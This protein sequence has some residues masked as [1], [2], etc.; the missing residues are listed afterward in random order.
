[1]KHEWTSGMI[2]PLYLFVQ[3]SEKIIYGT[4]VWN[5]HHAESDAI[6]YR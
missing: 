5:Q 2:S 6:Y 4:A 1:M 3:I